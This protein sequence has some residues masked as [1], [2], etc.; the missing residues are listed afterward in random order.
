MK[1]VALAA[2]LVAPFL[3]QSTG[4]DPG[5][6]DLKS[7]GVIALALIVGAAGVYRW[8][9]LPERKRTEVERTDRVA[10]ETRERTVLVQSAEKVHE[11][12][13]DLRRATQVV[14]DVARK[15]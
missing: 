6:T 4:G 14:A 7:L 11:A 12:V 2:F 9:V 13:A 10:A 5:F 8:G 3:A 15:A 1:F